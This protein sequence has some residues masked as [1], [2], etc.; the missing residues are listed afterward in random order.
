VDGPVMRLMIVIASLR[1]MLFG[2]ASRSGLPSEVAT[3]RLDTDLR[4]TGN[5]RYVVAHIQRHHG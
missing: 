4:R 2:A 5:L 3:F 1:L